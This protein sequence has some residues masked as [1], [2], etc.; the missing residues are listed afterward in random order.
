M[1]QEGNRMTKFL[2]DTKMS[3]V[4]DLLQFVSHYALNA[5]CGKY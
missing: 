2:K 5:I 4:D 1:I 3:T